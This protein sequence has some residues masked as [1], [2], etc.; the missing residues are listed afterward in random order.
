[1]ADYCSGLLWGLGKNADGTWVASDPIDT[2][3]S[4]SSFGEAASGELYVTDLNGGVYEVS[5]GS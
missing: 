1:L 2:G 5:A 4:V 3:L